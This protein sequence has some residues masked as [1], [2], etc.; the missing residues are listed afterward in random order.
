[1]EVT[2]PAVVTNENMEVDP[3]V[4]TTDQQEEITDKTEPENTEKSE[5]VEKSE[6]AK[7]PPSDPITD[8]NICAAT[9]NEQEKADTVV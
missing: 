8:E 6:E 5:K 9:N 2:E 4:A 7:E 3:I 1:M